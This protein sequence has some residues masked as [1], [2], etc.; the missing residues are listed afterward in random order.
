VEKEKK[1]ERETD[2]TV[3]TERPGKGVAKRLVSD[4]E[5]VQL[6]IREH[7]S[8]KSKTADAAVV[9]PARPD[10]PIREKKPYQV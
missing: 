6:A 8:E 1:K 9:G 4:E 3:W 5:V 2:L 10:K 7:V